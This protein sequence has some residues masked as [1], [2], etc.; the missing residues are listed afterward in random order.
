MKKFKSSAVLVALT[1]A[2]LLILSASVLHSQSAQ[3]LYQKALS[4]EKTQGN[5]EQA[6]AIYKK[7]IAGAGAGRALAARAQYYIGLCYE[8]LGATEAEK[9]FRKVIDQYPEQKESV[10]A[11]NERLAVL[12][13]S[14]FA[15]QS[16]GI[17]LRQ[18]SIPEGQPSPDGKSMAYTISHDSYENGDPIRTE[19]WYMPT[20]DSKQARKLDLEMP[21][22]SLLNFH[23]DGKTIA[24]AS[25]AHETKV[26]V[27][28]NYLPAKKQL[29]QRSKSPF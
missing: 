24:F 13:K 10:S 16:T 5:L 22:I 3:D 20:F 15:S 19:L 25:Q 6:I 27:M 8:K 23:P 28:G 9:A 26:W 17:V 29:P 1:A 18:V 2:A 7:V 12:T 4:Q 14:Q 11:A 21:D